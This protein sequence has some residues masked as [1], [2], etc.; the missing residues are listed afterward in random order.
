MSDTGLELILRRDRLI[1]AAALGFVVILAWAYVAWFAA[2]SMQPATA[3]MGGDMSMGMDMGDEPVVGPDM[4]PSSAPWAAP[5]FVFVA[6]MW[7]A[8][9]VGMMTPSAAP[10]ILLYARVGRSAA[11][12]GKPFASSAWF[13]A[14]YLLAWTGFAV[15]A[16]GAQGALQ[17]LAVLGPMMQTTNRFVGGGI[18]VAAGIYQFTPLKNACLGQCR[19]PLTFIQ[20]HGGFRRDTAGSVRLGL[21]HG[22]YCIGCCWALMLL[23]FV[24]GVMNPVW[25][26][27]IVALVLVEKL[28]PS[29]RW[30]PWLA[31]AALIAAGFWLLVTT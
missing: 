14:G 8:M 12:Q 29:A 13:A 7:T 21:L 30:V 6:T 27:G 11:A 22:L 3:D 9:M 28:L 24:G 1:T 4:T 23:L 15:L 5:D 16:T 25:I 31:G 20:Q 17:Q 2:L 19:A 26:A 10:M 18:L